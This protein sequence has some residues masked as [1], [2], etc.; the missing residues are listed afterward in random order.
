M[1]KIL[2]FTVFIF[3]FAITVGFASNLSISLITNSLVYQGVQITNNGKQSYKLTPTLNNLGSKVT[4]CQPLNPRYPN[5]G[6]HSDPAAVGQGELAPGAKCTLWLE[7]DTTG[8]P[9]GTTK[10]SVSVTAKSKNASP[11][12]DTIQINYNK[13]LYA[14][15]NFWKKEKN[16]YIISGLAKWDGKNWSDVGGGLHYNTVPG[17][18]YALALHNGNLYVGGFFNKVGTDEIDANSIAEWNGKTWTTLGGG[19]YKAYDPSSVYPGTIYALTP[20]QRGLFAVGCFGAVKNKAQEIAT[21]IAFWNGFEWSPISDIGL[22]FW[23]RG[24]VPYSNGIGY[25]LY[26]APSSMYGLQAGGFFEAAGNC[27]A[28]GN[29][30]VTKDKLY[31]PVL[32]LNLRFLSNIELQNDAPRVGTV[33]T[34]IEYN[35][36]LYMAGEFDDFTCQEP[37]MN[38]STDNLVRCGDNSWLPMNIHSLADGIYAMA[39]YKGNLYIGGAFLHLGSPFHS[40]TSGLI[41]Y[42]NV[43]HHCSYVVELIDTTVRALT[44]DGTNLYVG[45]TFLES[46]IKS[47]NVAAFDGQSIHPLGKGLPNGSVNH[48]LIVPGITLSQTEPKFL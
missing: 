29:A 3:F 21:S 30:G 11:E 31:S 40:V 13:D 9:F 6:F 45:G 38:K 7:A 20:Y 32:N 34:I 39:A 2:P 27:K 1:G 10:G 28:Y 8:D 36:Q 5:W 48:L 41:A 18:G 24:A 14:T 16:R 22:R 33:R 47:K 4:I 37:G 19:V 43:N 26:A 17:A 15:G 44:T 12:T 42:D 35:D 23:G 46:K 25:T